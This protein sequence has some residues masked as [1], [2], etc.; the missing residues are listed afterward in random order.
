MFEFYSTT[1]ASVYGTF[2]TKK[3]DGEIKSP[4]AHRLMD[5]EDQLR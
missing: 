3:K 1:P 2:I 5:F 4:P